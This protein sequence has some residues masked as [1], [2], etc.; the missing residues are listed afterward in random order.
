MPASK[1]LVK[2]VTLFAQ[3]EDAQYLAIRGL[4]FK[5]RKS[6]AEIMREVITCYLTEKI[7]KDAAL[8]AEAGG[9]SVV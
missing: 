3:I 1:K 7:G 4:A 8:K 2:P 9:T 6:I 5:D